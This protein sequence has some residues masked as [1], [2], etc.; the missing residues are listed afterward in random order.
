MRDPL[1]P[2]SL[3][4]I[5][6]LHG[7]GVKTLMLS[8]DNRHAVSAIATEA[9]ID[10]ARGE[11]LPEDKL[12]IIEEYGRR[13]V[14]GMVGDGINDAPALARADIGF[15]MGAAG[16]D[17]AIETADVALMD[18]DLGKLPTFLRLSRATYAV[19]VQNIVLALGIK[20]SF[21]SWPSPVRPRYGWR[22]SPTWRQPAG[23]RQWIAS[24][25]C[26]DRLSASNGDTPCKKPTVAP[27]AE[28]SSSLSV[29]R[30]SS[31]QIGTSDAARLHR[32]CHAPVVRLDRLGPVAGLI[33]MT[34]DH[35]ARYV[36][37][38]A[39]GLGW[40]DS[41]VG[42]VASRCSPPWWPGMASSIPATRCATRDACW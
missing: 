23:H 15:S 27:Y 13:G 21:W 7:L 37:P 5:E 41:S 11:L 1:K 30:E 40:A 2:T 39:W 20:P 6:A 17:V 4:A 18:D 8:G 36:V 25:A 16:S 32:R 34:L 31:F 22:C 38:D 3:A 29:S 12:A 42:R 9:G 24:A 35:L 28:P 19:L 33:T 10:S 26:S 14:T